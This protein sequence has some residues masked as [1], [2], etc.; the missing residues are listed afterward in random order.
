MFFSSRISPFHVHG[1]L[2]TE[3]AARHGRGHFGDVAN[4]GGQV[5][6]HRIDRVGQILPGARHAR[7]DGLHAQSSF[8]ADFAGHARHFR[9]ERAELLDHRIDGFLE[10][11]NLSAHVDR[12]F[13]RKIAIG[14]GDGHVGDVADL[15]GEVRC[16]RVDVVGEIL[17]RAG[18]AQHLGLTA[19]LAFRADFA[20]HARHFRGK[21]PELLDHRV[22]GF[23]ELQ[24]F[25]LSRP[26]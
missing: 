24:D 2:A 13:L 15:A 25:A 12:D 23:L 18:H 8:G 1:D 6:T 22:H 16:H 10:L 17:P 11:Q 5:R 20:R 9:G 3:I 21:G 26:P 14:H 7:H 19:Q 4:L